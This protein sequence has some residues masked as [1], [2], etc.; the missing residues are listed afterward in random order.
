MEGLRVGDRCYLPRDAADSVY[1]DSPR[2]LFVQ[3]GQTGELAFE[4]CPSAASGWCRV[5]RVGGEVVSTVAADLPALPSCTMY[6]GFFDGIQFGW[7][8]L[9]VM[10]AVAAFRMMQAGAK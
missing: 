2:A 7:L 4:V 3:N 8:V 10:V 1:S 9:A 6:G 5:S